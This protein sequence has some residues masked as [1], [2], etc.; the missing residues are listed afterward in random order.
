M[1]FSPLRHMSVVHLAIAS[2]EISEDDT[3]TRDADVASH[4]QRLIRNRARW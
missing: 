3:G 2:E 1:Y 4:I